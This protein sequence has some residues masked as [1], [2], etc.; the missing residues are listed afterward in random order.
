MRER[1]TGELMG[2]SAERTGQRDAISREA[3]DAFAV[4]PHR[5]AAAAVAS[6]RFADEVTPVDVRGGRA[7]HS[8]ELKQT[9]KATALLG[10]CG[11]GGLSAAALERV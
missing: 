5:R 10:I 1:S 11:G 9:G 2:E 7:A 4:Q 8:N 3:Q 6:G